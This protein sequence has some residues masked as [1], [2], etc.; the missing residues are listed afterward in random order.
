MILRVLFY[1]TDPT[2]YYPPLPNWV[3]VCREYTEWKTRS[4]LLSSGRTQDG[5][6]GQLWGRCYVSNSC[7]KTTYP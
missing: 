3:G 1:C 4:G 6:A 7:G 2:L 5:P